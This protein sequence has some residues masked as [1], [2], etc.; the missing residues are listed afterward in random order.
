VE[1]HICIAQTALHAVLDY[2]VHV[3][4]DATSSRS[5]ENWRVG[6]DRMRQAGVVITSTEM[7]I[8]ELLKRAGTDE[9]RAVLPLVK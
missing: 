5:V 1:T 4:S 7:V 9:F 3:V 6:L 8:Y 2:I